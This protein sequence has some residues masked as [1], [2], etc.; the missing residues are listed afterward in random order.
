[1][2]TRDAVTISEPVAAV[3]SEPLPHSVAGSLGAWPANSTSARS[4][5]SA[6]ETSQ[7]RNFLSRE[8]FSN[9]EGEG[10]R[11]RLDLP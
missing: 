10:A 3:P 4:R 8:D 7:P 1:M 11:L 6:L 5:L 9:S 2:S